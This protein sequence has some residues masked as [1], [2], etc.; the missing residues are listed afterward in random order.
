MYK[1]QLKEKV[2]DTDMSGNSEWNAEEGH[3]IIFLCNR[4]IIEKEPSGSKQKNFVHFW[5]SIYQCVWSIEDVNISKEN[6]RNWNFISCV[7]EYRK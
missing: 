3:M 7:Y 4:L 5:I 6:L 1:D 2:L